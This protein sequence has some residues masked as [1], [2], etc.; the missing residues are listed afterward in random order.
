[1]SDQ[2]MKRIAIEV[3]QRQL[4]EGSGHDWTHTS[5]VWNLALLIADSEGGNRY[6]TS[7]A[8]LLHGIG[9]WKLFDGDEVA[10]EAE[11]QVELSI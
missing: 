3:R 11:G 8:A 2:I 5:R 6:V 9:D 7:L 10:G 4:G 1:M